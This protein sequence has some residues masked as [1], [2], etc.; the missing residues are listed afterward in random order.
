MIQYTRKRDSMR[1]EKQSHRKLELILGLIFGFIIEAGLFYLFFRFEK[2]DWADLQR[3]D[4]N[5]FIYWGFL[6][7][8][9]IVHRKLM[10]K[11]FIKTPFLLY[12][13]P[14]SG[15]CLI[16]CAVGGFIIP[17]RLFYEVIK[18]CI[19][20]KKC[21]KD[22]LEKYRLPDG[23][24]DALLSERGL[25]Y[26]KGHFVNTVDGSDFGSSITITPSGYKLRS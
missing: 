21:K 25:K 26:E 14:V 4:L 24:L 3:R 9:M 16:M 12:I 7:S 18:D 22:K 11:I 2:R 17:I 19:Q 23:A 20:K 8:G 13:W 1:T 10:L 6:F 5:N 15:I